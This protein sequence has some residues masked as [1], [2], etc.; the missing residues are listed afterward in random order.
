MEPTLPNEITS[1]SSIWHEDEGHPSH[2]FARTAS[3]QRTNKE[4]S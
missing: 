4:A 3:M 2:A 1:R